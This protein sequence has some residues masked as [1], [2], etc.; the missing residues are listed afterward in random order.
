MKFKTIREAA[1]IWVREMNFIDIKLIQDAISGKE[2]EWNEITPLTVG[3]TVYCSSGIGLDGNFY[4]GNGEVA[5]INGDQ[6]VVLMDDVE[7]NV[8]ADKCNVEEESRDCFPMR[9]TMFQPKDRCDEKWIVDN[10]QQVAECGFRIFE[11]DNYGIF[12]GIDGCGYDFY[13]E[14]WIPLYKARGLQW[15][16]EEGEKE[17]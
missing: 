3:E 17:V 12:L 5:E 4:R 14:H 7:K 6:I 16:E 15:H 8:L 2:Y 13:A 1:E 9:S 11:H 10:L